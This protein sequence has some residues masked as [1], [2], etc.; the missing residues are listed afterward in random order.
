MW[1]PKKEEE[2]LKAVNS[3][4]LEESSTFDV[5]AAL[6]SK[7]IEIAKDI[8][9]MSND[10]GVIIFGIGED[11]NGRLKIATPIPLNGE[12]ERITSVAQTSITEPPRFHIRTIPTSKDS[13]K[14]YIVVEIPPSERAPHM[15]V[16]QGDHRYYGRNAKGN[17]LLSEAEVERLYER[18]KKLAVD[19]K[20]LLENEIQQA[21]YPPHTKFGYLHVFARP[22]FELTGVLDRMGTPSM[23]TGRLFRE[24]VERIAEQNLLKIEYYPRFQPYLNDWEFTA[25]GLR[26]KTSFGNDLKDDAPGDA[27]F[28]RVDTDGMGHLFCG[29]AAELENERFELF[30]SVIVGNIFNFLFFMGRLFQQANYIGMVNIGLAVTGIKDAVYHSTD[31]TLRYPRKKYESDSYKKVG[32]IDAISLTKPDLLLGVLEQMLTHLFRALTQGRENPFEELKLS[33]LNVTSD[34]AD[35]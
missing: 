34:P 9:A 21:P 20:A 16:V 6:P 8:A 24:I 22:T 17:F 19:L 18:R 31:S 14:G 3:D 12:P 7:N 15:V 26:G 33:L 30:W 5:K 27:L 28:L 13:S 2:I 32:R 4:A 25:E 29:R 11:K 23:P 10:G 35:G 1:A